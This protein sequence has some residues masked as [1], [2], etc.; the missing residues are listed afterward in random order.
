MKIIPCLVNISHEKSEYCI[1]HSKT[2]FNYIAYDIFV[3]ILE[4]DIFNIAFIIF[5]SLLL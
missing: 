2:V 3:F 4:F 5:V 1:M